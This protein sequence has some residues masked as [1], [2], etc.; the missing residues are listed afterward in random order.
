MGQ[1]HERQISYHSIGQESH[2]SEERNGLL[3]VT[4][5]FGDPEI[6]RVL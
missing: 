2:Q 4:Q 3:A 1:E 6:G 5:G